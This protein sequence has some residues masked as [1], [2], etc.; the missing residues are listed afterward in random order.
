VKKLVC[1]SA[2][3]LSTLTNRLD[4]GYENRILLDRRIQEN[5]GLGQDS[6]VIRVKSEKQI[7]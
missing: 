4:N 5:R 2:Y 7:S 1:E 6:I 3:P